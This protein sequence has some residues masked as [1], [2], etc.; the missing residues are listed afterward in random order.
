MRLFLECFA[1]CL[2][3]SLFGGTPGII[4]STVGVCIILITAVVDWVFRES[5]V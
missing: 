4:G 5:R 3:A 1:V 2:I